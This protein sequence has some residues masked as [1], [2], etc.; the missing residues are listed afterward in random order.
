MHWKY[1]FL[2]L[3][4][5]KRVF[6]PRLPTGGWLFW[7]HRSAILSA[8]RICFYE[9]VIEPLDLNG[10]FVV[11]QRLYYVHW[12]RGVFFFSVETL[13]NSRISQKTKF[14]FASEWAECDFH[15]LDLLCLFAAV[16]FW[17]CGVEKRVG[18]ECKSIMFTQIWK[19]FH[20]EKLCSSCTPTENHVSIQQALHVPVVAISIKFV[21]NVGVWLRAQIGAWGCNPG[22]KRQIANLKASYQQV[23]PSSTPWPRERA[24][25]QIT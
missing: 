22:K 21:K 25:N 15:Y 19:S 3:V 2:A 9:Y 17:C 24:L 6:W 16:R 23:R 1:L 20:S 18:L 5:A 8:L 11:V 10:S 14:A 12:A 4:K 7:K 13:F